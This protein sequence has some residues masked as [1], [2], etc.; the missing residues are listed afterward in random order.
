MSPATSVGSYPSTAEESAAIETDYLH[1]PENITKTIVT[2]KLK[3]IRSK[4]RQSAD[5][6]SRS[7]HGRVVLLYFD[8]VDHQTLR[9]LHLGLNPVRFLP[10]SHGKIFPAHKIQMNTVM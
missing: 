7:G 4:F 1:K 5:D 3:A 10:D 9:R 2:F 8:G 6:G